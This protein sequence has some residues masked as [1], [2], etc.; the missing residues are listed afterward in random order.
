MSTDF[1]KGF[2]L[3]F[4]VELYTSRLDDAEHFKPPNLIQMPRH[5]NQANFDYPQKNRVKRYPY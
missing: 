1:F 5:N 3:G 2:R 4:I